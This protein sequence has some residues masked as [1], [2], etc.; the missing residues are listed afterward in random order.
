MQRNLLSNIQGI[1]LTQGDDAW[2]QIHDNSGLFSVKFTYLA[3][4][5]CI[6]HIDNS[7]NHVSLF[8]PSSQEELDTFQ[9][10]SLFLTITSRQ[11]SHKRELASYRC[12]VM[13]SSQDFFY[14]FPYLD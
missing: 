9:G 3:I 8:F 10:A 12:G 2:L 14:F 13:A 4:L 5:A 6:L 7:S 1:C 11:G